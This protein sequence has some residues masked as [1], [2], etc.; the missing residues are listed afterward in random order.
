VWNIGGGDSGVGVKGWVQLLCSRRAT[1]KLIMV[2]REVCLQVFVA[3]VVRI[4]L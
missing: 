3:M 1:V 4:C 2:F